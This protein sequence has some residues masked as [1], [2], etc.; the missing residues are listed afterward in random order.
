ML[1]EIAGMEISLPPLE[2]LSNYRAPAHSD[3]LIDWLDAQA[4]KCDVLIAGCETLGYGGLIASRISHETTATI[5][6]RLETLRHIK[7]RHP[8]LCIL[9]FNL[10]TRIPAYNSAVEEPLYWAEHGTSL[11]QLSQLMDRAG[12][13]EAVDTELHQLRARLPEEHVNDFLGRRLRNHIVNLFTLELAA[14]EIFDLLIV[15]SDDTS[16]FGLS[17]REKRWIS[18]S[19]ALFA[20]GDRLLMYPGADEVGS[21]LVA[22]VMNALKGHAPTFQIDYTVP[23]GDA[24]TAAFEDSAVSITV[25]R[26]IYAAGAAIVPEGGDILLL[27]NTPRSS[28]HQWPLPYSP[29]ELRQRKPYLEAA[30]ERLARWIETGKSVAVADV[31]HANGADVLLV[32]MLQDA[33][34][35]LKLDAYGGWNTAG[36]AIGTTVA[37]ACIASHFGR[38]STL[39]RRFVAHRLIEDWA[40]MGV[41]RDQAMAWLEAETGHREPAPEMVEKTA[42]WIED[43]L[44]PLVDQLG[45]GYRIAPGSLCLPWKRTFETDFDLEATSTGGETSC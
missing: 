37:Q 11:H 26:Q 12:H 3:R 21:I 18:E 25:E 17:S 42:T 44:G 34:L 33:G 39:Q 31:A 6:A 2:M 38:E 27:V 20:L 23:G 30:V 8:E 22:R 28:E 19:A 45:T 14:N 7:V 13:G 40:Y 16:T 10:I 29:D 43:R 1:A 32:E 9:G 5:T 15:S 41:V 36:N 24:V 4:S 35:L